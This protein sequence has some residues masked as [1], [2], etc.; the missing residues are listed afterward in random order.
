MTLHQ[1]RVVINDTT[2]RD[3]EQT[4]GVAFT[5]EEK[6]AIARALDAAGVVELEVGIPAMGPEEQDAIRAVVEAGLSARAIA[7]CR[8]HENDVEDALACGVS[9][10]NVSIPVSDQQISHKIGRDRDWVLNRIG[11]VVAHARARGLDVAVGGEDS[12]RADLG[13]LLEVAAVAEAAGAR[14]FR[15]ADTLGILDPFRTLDAF[16]RLRAS[17]KL[18]LEI[19]AHDDLGMAT[20][21]SLAAVLGGANHVN[22]TVNGL[23]ERAGNAPL[24]EVVMG[25]HHLHGRPTGVMTD[26]LLACSELVARASGRPVPVNKSIVG[27]AIFTHESGIHIHGLLRDPRNYQSFDPQELGRQHRLVLGKHSG[28]S[29]VL[30]AYAELGLSIEEPQ[31]RA[32][33]ARVRRHVDAT[34]QIPGQPELLR[35]YEETA[36]RDAGLLAPG[37]SP[38]VPS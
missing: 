22:T 33:L 27:D 21:N 36:L 28:V 2:L 30:H 29:A 12:S 7:W 26:R 14:R 25:L 17:L 11:E 37:N 24:E 23:G 16:R 32:V 18:E 1:S 8:M 38:L 34:K 3:G 4:A 35:F 31:A 5:A 10:V 15:F 13:F 19:H 9:M 20:A 6:L